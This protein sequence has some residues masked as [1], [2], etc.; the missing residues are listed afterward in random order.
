MFQIALCVVGVL[1]AGFFFCGVRLDKPTCFAD[2]CGSLI[3]SIKSEAEQ[4]GKGVMQFS[5]F[6]QFPALETVRGHSRARCSVAVFAISAHRNAEP[7]RVSAILQ[8]SV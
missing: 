6:V 7:A 4:E 2:C 3:L 1:R 8:G 5:I